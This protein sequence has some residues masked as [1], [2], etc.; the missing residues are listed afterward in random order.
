MTFIRAIQF[1]SAGCNIQRNAWK[2]DSAID[3]RHALFLNRD[4]ILQ[5]VEPN[6]GGE[7]QLCPPDFDPS[8]SIDLC[9][10]DINATDWEVV[11]Q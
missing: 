1:A 6:I 3:D 2:C 9:P 8:N 10:E 7:A 11:Q 5:W 4:G